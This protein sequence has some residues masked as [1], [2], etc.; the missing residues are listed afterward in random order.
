MNELLSIVLWQY[1][2]T[3][4]ASVL[5]RLFKMLSKKTY[6]VVYHIQGIDEKNNKKCLSEVG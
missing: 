4:R 5:E 3:L 6:R 1:E 2:V